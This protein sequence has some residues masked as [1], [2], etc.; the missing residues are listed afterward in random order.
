[1]RVEAFGVQLAVTER[2]A[3]VPVLLV[4]GMAASAAS[5][6]PVLDA[7]AGEARLIAYDRRGYGASGA[8]QPYER[9]TVNEQAEDATALLAARVREPALVCGADLGALVC[10]D[11]LVRHAERVRGAVLLAPP[12]YAFVAG[13]TEALAAERVRLEEALRAEGPAAAVDA[14]LAGASGVPVSATRRERARR[15]HRAFFADYGG[16]ASWAV[17][18]ATLRAIRAPVV[19]VDGE[20]PSPPAQA[21]AAALEGL[22]PNVRRSDGA[23]PL[24]ALRDLL[25][26]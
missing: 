5:W 6:D 10:L 4:H 3:G 21:A 17:T 20:R 9:T 16:L 23:D 1:M 12:L 25:A 18:R 7:L 26:A 15:D 22:L 19:V 14:Y 8:P 13:A 2:G 24:P 11:L